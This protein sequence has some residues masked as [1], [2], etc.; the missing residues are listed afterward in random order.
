VPVDG[1]K[2]QD[3]FFAGK[4]ITL[5]VGYSV[6]G[7]FDATARVVGRHLGNHL[8]GQPGI[9]VKNVPGAGSLKL[10]NQL[11]NSARRDG[12]EIGAVGREI[13][14]ASILGVE[15]ARFQST[16]LGWLGSVSREGA[17]CVA[18]KNSPVRS[19]DDL[20]NKKIEFIVGGTTGQSLTV[21]LPYL[22]N[23]LLGTQIKVISGYPGSE[24]IMLAMERG[25]VHGLC[26]VTLSTL[27]TRHSH[28]LKEGEIRVL[29]ETSLESKRSL[30]AVPL[31]TE[32]TKNTRHLQILSVHLASTQ[33][34][35][36]FV[37]PPGLPPKRLATL[38]AGFDK[39]T[40]DPAFK[41][42]ME[43]QKLDLDAM[44][45]TEMARKIGELANIPA[46]VI[47]AAAKAT[48]KN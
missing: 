9:V 11:F 25:E 5:Y 1:V 37:A 13:P 36:P 23:N 43:R 14:V 33:W 35:R 48:Q 2:A 15:N 40:S 34:V 12:T 26:Y 16:E 8:P 19:A 20:I 46:D 39:M 28:A 31:I 38:R 27:R 47:Q 3:D 4:T 6:G 41:K 21:G 10:T 17:V 18:S 44:S 30:P 42:D 32:F 29:L 22:F 24:A 7:G 45:G